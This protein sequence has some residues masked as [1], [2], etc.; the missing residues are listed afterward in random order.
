MSSTLEAKLILVKAEKLIA[1]LA[2]AATL[3]AVSG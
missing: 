2:L 1:T 3:A